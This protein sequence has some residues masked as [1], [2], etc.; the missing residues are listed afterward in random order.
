LEADF[1]LMNRSVNRAH[2]FF[3]VSA[4]IV[5]RGHQIRPRSAQCIDSFV[6][7][8]M[9][10]GSTRGSPSG[11]GLRVRRCGYSH[12]KGQRQNERDESESTDNPMLH[13]SFLLNR[14]DRSVV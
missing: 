3:A 4:E 1:E 2:G 11:S 12:G 5:R 10:F 7:V 8:M 9:L 6:D 13:E 14:V